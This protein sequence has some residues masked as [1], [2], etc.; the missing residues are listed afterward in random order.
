MKNDYEIRGEVTAIFL[1]RR[2]APNLETLIDTEDLNKLMD[3]PY[4]WSCNFMK[5]TETYYVVSD[6]RKEGKRGKNLLHRFLM[7]N[8]P[9]SLVVDHINHNTLDNR[10]TNLRIITSAENFQNMNGPY[11]NSKSGIRGVCWHKATQ[12]WYAFIKVN[13]KCKYLGLFEDIKEAEKVAIEARKQ[14]MPFFV[15]GASKYEG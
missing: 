11:K 10:K 1:K 13:G 8:P 9:K 14:M 2:N 15:E 5:N 3:Y 6:F 12:K 7:D 4:R